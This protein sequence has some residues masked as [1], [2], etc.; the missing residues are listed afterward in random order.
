M[1]Q[2]HRFAGCG[3]AQMAARPAGEKGCCFHTRSSLSRLSIAKNAGDFPFL[4]SALYHNVQ[5]KGDS[6]RE[7]SFFPR[8]PPVALAK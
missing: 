6:L 7:Q 3:I 8:K 4:L 1:G 5:Q 2:G